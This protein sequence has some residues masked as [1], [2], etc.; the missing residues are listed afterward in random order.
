MAPKLVAQQ[1]SSQVHRV[2][3]SGAH[4]VD[5]KCHKHHF[6]QAADRC[7]TCLRPVCAACMQQDS[8]GAVCLDCRQQKRA[9]RRRSAML[10]TLALLAA[11]SVGMLVLHFYEPPFEYGMRIADVRGWQA[12]VENEPCGERGIIGLTDVMLAARNA[13]GVLKHAKQFESTC[14]KNIRLTWQTHAAHK[15]LRQWDEAISDA[16][17]LIADG[18]EDKDFRWWRAAAYEAK[19]DLA[20][21]AKDYTQSMALQPT[22]EHIPINLAGVYEKMNLPCDVATA[23]EQLVYTHPNLIHD[24]WI[25]E[26]LPGF[27]DA[28]DGHEGIG[29]PPVYSRQLV[30]IVQHG[31][32]A[33]SAPSAFRVDPSC[34]FV[35]MRAEAAEKN[36]ITSSDAT[37]L[38]VSTSWGPVHGT[39]AR[40]DEVRTWRSTARQV[41]VLLARDLPKDVN[42]ILGINF[43]SRWVG[44]E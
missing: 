2:D 13:Q 41:D 44:Q 7:F 37:E 5:G 22:M 34:M 35:V 14:G 32:I 16:T 12:V 33:D 42:G 36:G 17:V 4:D 43:L 1:S 19:G 26:R 8:D 10:S 38:I 27:R 18:P 40:V 20:H 24:E 30:D 29:L 25:S 11:G 28:C 23:L 15:E 21:A 6:T 3:S 39:L 31:N 9:S